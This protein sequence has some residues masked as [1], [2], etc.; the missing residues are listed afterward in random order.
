MVIQ[1]LFRSTFPGSGSMAGHWLGDND[2]N[3]A[4][5]KYN[6]IGL[7]EFNLFGIPYVGADTCGFFNDATEELCERWMQLGAFNPFY[8]NHNSIN[9]KDQDPGVFSERAKDSIRKTVQLRYSLIPHLYT[10]FYKVNIEGGTVVRSLVHE[11]PRDRFTPDVDEQFLWYAQKF[12][13]IFY[14]FFII[15]TN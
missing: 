6:I 4:H 5:L 1:I 3:W 14:L 7:L 8:R 10:L 11:F 2:S 13:D 15:Q 9:Q 12:F